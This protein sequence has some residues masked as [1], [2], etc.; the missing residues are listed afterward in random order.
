MAKMKVRWIGRFDPNMRLLRLASFLWGT[1]P[2]D[3]GHRHR[4]SLALRPAWWERRVERDGW[5]LTVFGVRLHHQSH[6]R[7]TFV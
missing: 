4:L 6:P 1:H 2:R 5:L 3:G 7:G